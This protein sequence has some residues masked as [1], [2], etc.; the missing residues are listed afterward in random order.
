[1]AIETT[2]RGGILHVVVTGPWPTVQEFREA[3]ERAIASGQLTDETLELL[4]VRGV[5]G[6]LPRT[7]DIQVLGARFTH[8]PK[9]RAFLVASDVQY[10]VGRM[11]G[12]LL[13]DGPRVFRDETRAIAWLKD[14]TG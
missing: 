13:K 2:E 14:P 10:G 8:P 6:R 5:V 1:M 4:D 11:A 9:R 12:A 3:R 7:D